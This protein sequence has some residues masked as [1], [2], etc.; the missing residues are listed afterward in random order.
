[1]FMIIIM[2]MVMMTVTL[3]MFSI[4]FIAQL[5]S[6]PLYGSHQKQIVGSLVS[7]D[8]N[9]PIISKQNDQSSKE[10]TP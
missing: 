7:K 5:C 3:T 2:R 9:N 8:P 6:R 10:L 1:M 4:F